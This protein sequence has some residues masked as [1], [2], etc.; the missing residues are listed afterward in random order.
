ML[1]RGARVYMLLNLLYP[2]IRD[3]TSA[4]RLL[5]TIHIISLFDMMYGLVITN[6]GNFP[7]LDIMTWY[8][9]HLICVRQPTYVYLIALQ[10]CCCRLF[11]P[12]EMFK[13]L[14]MI[15][16]TGPI[17]SNCMYLSVNVHLPY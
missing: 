10:G 12:I 15:L 8:I 17:H 4:R 13:Q 14:R 3:L 7:A 9:F 16:F 5:A 11:L 1:G 6:F 2:P